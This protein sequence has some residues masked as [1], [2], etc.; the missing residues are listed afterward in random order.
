MGSGVVP[1]SRWGPLNMS[2]IMTKIFDAVDH[3]RVGGSCGSDWE[4]TI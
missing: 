3:G 4:E 2:M 1:N